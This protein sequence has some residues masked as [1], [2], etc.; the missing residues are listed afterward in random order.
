MCSLDWNLIRLW[1]VNSRKMII[2][3]ADT[4]PVV[5]ALLSS[6]PITGPRSGRL[7]RA[8]W[9]EAPIQNDIPATISRD[10]FGSFWITV[11]APSTK[12]DPTTSIKYPAITGPGIVLSRPETFGTN[13]TSMNT[14]PMTY[15]ILRDATPVICVKATAPGFITSGTPPATPYNRF[16]MP[17]PARAPYTLLKSIARGSRLETRCIEIAS[18]F[19]CMEIITPRNRKDGTST[20]KSTL[21]SSPRPG[22]SLGTPTHAASVT[23]SIS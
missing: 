15:P 12:S 14:A 9:N 20:Q 13:A 7:N 3:T 19:T 18:P 16:P 11:R 23:L 5:T 22:H 17:A 4:P 8:N 2:S 10:L 1:L 6:A 21:K